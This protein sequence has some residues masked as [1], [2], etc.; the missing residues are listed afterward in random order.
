MEQTRSRSKK[1]RNVGVPRLWRRSLISYTA[2]DTVKRCQLDCIWCGL[3][4]VFF[5]VDIRQNLVK[6]LPSLVKFLLSLVKSFHLLSNPCHLLSNLQQWSRRPLRTKH[7]CKRP[8][9]RCGTQSIDLYHTSNLNRDR[10][11]NLHT[12]L[13]TNRLLVLKVEEKNHFNRWK[14]PTLTDL[15]AKALLQMTGPDAACRRIHFASRPGRSGH[16]GFDCFPAI[17]V[18]SI[19]TS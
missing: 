1:M 15:S 6:S 9:C 17:A 7:N 11:T 2:L 12:T 14:M 16:Y 5:V 18:L 10:A 4:T 3:L 19:H 8:K 13:V